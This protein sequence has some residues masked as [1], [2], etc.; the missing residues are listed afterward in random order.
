M[1]Y[2]NINKFAKIIKKTTE[3]EWDDKEYKDTVA[4]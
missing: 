2:Y 4:T 1:K 3:G